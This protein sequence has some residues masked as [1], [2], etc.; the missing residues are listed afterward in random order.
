MNPAPTEAT[1]WAAR[2]VHEA[3][4]A[5]L[6]AKGGDPVPWERLNAMVQATYVEHVTN[7]MRALRDAPHFLLDHARGSRLASGD[8]ALFWNAMVDAI[9]PPEAK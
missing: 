3:H 7:V 5:K 6:R 2:A 4:S 1:L 9:A 8:A